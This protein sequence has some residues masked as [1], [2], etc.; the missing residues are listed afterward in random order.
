M[1]YNYDVIRD[2]T[3]PSYLHI[4]SMSILAVALVIIGILNV[5]LTSDT[6]IKIIS[7]FFL[8]GTGL[9]LFYTYAIRQGRP[10]LKNGIYTI[11]IENGYLTWNMKLY[12]DSYRLNLSEIK[13]ITESN[14]RI[15][16]ALKD[17][18]IQSISINKIRNKSKREEFLKI[19]RSLQSAVKT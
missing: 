1:Q 6:G 13:S 15:E 16:F 2:W 12:S 19:I 3:R 5:R 11:K 8:I 18:S 4:V 10:F 9:L 7:I 17:N 14:Y